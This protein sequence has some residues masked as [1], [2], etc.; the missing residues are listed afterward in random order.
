MEDAF[1]A[2]ADSCVLASKA[3]RRKKARARERVIRY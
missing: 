3:L 1:A 2:G